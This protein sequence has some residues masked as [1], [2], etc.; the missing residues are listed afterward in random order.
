MGMKSRGNFCIIFC[1]KSSI[2][3]NKDKK[4]NICIKFDQ[5]KRKD[6]ND[7]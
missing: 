4:C 6:S 1:T 3:K 7:N 5:F 2:C